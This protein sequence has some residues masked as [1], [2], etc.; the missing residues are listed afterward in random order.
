MNRDPRAV[1]LAGRLGTGKTALAV[2]A[3][4]VLAEAG[5]AAAVL[6]LDRLA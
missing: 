3:Y 2:E 4:T 1:L 5:F 6:D